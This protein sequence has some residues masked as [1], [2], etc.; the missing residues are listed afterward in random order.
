MTAKTGKW[1]V[2]LRILAAS[3]VNVYVYAGIAVLRAAIF[4]SDGGARAV[5]L[6][7]SSAML[8]ILSNAMFLNRI[9]PFAAGVSKTRSARF[10]AFML[11]IRDVEYFVAKAAAWL[12]VIVP[13][14]A[15]IFLFAR[16]G[17]FR[18]LFELAPLAAAYAISLK[19]TRLDAAVIMSRT[20][21][22]TGFLVLFSALAI[23]NILHGLEYLRPWLKGAAY[24]FILAY[25]IVRNQEDIDVNIFNKKHVEKS[26]LPKNM[27]RFNMLSVCMVFLI[28]LLI[29]N[30]RNA[31]ASIAGLLGMVIAY[32]A[33][34]VLWIL[35]FFISIISTVHKVDAQPQNDLF[36]GFRGISPV[37]NF[38]FNILRNF[39]ILYI[40][41]RILFELARKIPGYARNIAGLIAK[42]FSLDKG[43]RPIEEFDYTDES[44]TVKPEWLRGRFKTAGKK[45]RK[46]RKKLK[47]I[48]DP[49]EKVRRMY[50]IVLDMLQISGIKT[51]PCDTTLDILKKAAPLGSVREELSALT[52]VYNCVRYGE[53]VP[54]PEMMSEALSCYAKTAEGFGFTAEDA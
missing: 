1:T 11:N 36:T 42:L 14:A 46:A 18:V 24:F 52:D 48:T 20:K 41:Y 43:A 45:R 21:V 35:D 22:F 6:Y 53:M 44:E 16:H 27:R 10:A 8:A 3:A 15:G 40:L 19:N 37:G 17:I 50:A 9:P 12:P 31:I 54:G 4:G 49:V 29:S 25:L 32:V 51:E 33:Y 13:L 47:Y 5:L 39:T 28:I 30:F 23:S 2:L 38:I 26:T 7:I 34:A